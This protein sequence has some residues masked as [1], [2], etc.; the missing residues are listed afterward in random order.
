MGSGGNSYAYCE[1]NP[2]CQSDPAGHVLLSVN[3]KGLILS[4][5][6]AVPS[7]IQ[8]AK[9]MRGRKPGEG[10][11]LRSAVSERYNSKGIGQ[12]MTSS[13]V[14]ANVL[15]Q[16]TASQSGIKVA[17][18]PRSEML[19]SYKVINE[20]ELFITSV[21]EERIEFYPSSGLPEGKLPTGRYRE[22]A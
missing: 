11:H 21:V 12:D 4:A 18:P 5:S 1:G 16:Q 3:F 14:S 19:G 13:G 9:V 15:P 8:T 7:T 6:S 17:E 2:V 22:F 10:V 20:E